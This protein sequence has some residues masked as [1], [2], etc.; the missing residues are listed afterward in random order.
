MSTRGIAILGSTGSIGTT[1]LR[2]IERHRDRFHVAALTAFSNSVL[3]TRQA[4][5]QD[6]QRPPEKPAAGTG[7]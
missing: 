3:L 4:A 2:V 6:V 1:A 7:P 5:Q